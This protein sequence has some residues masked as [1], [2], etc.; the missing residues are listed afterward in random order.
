ML[1]ITFGVKN[2]YSQQKFQTEKLCKHP[3]FLSD[4][5]D[6]SKIH[7]LLGSTNYTDSIL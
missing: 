6:D 2:T 7:R 1:K 4:L 5:S 3:F